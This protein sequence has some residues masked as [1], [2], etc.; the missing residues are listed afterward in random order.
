MSAVQYIGDGGTSGTVIGKTSTALVAFYG[1]TPVSQRASALLSSD[2][3]LF[4]ITTGSFVADATSTVSGVFG[5]N[6]TFVRQVVAALQEIRATLVA[7]GIHAGH[8]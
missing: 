4:A 2:I 6:S 8:T 1:E 7:A 5:F 3:S